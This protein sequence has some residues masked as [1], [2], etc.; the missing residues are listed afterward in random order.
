[1]RFLIMAIIALTAWQYGPVLYGA[2][3]GQLMGAGRPQQQSTASAPS[4]RP[5]VVMYATRS[6]GYCA[7]ARRFFAEHNIAYVERNVEGRSPYRSEW[8]RLGAA[9]VPTFVLDGEEII[10]GWDERRLRARLL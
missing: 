1:M 5:V 3:K 9:G 10:K 8:Q 6:C 7:R 4:G 2:G